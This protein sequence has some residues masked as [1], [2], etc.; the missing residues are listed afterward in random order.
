MDISESLK[1]AFDKL[2]KHKI[3]SAALD[4]EVILSFVLNKPKEYLFAHPKNQLT[5]RQLVKFKKFVRRRCRLEPVAYLTGTKEFYGLDFFINKNVLIPRPE[6][7]LLIEEVIKYINKLPTTNYKLTIAD[8]GTGSG[9]IAITLKK[10][11]PNTEMNAV[12]LSAPALATARRNARFHKVKIKFYRGRL[13]A[14]LSGRPPDIIVANL[15]YL[16]SDYKNSSNFSSLKY[17]PRIALDG[18]RTG[19]EIYEK[20]FCQIKKSSMPK[21]IFCEI[22][23]AYQKKLKKIINNYFPDSSVEI[24]PD[25]AGLPRL[26]IIYPNIKRGRV[27]SG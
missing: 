1:F 14:P 15:P 2:A 16:V 8:I 19:L 20:L 13:L 10:L 4:A 27:S 12:D 23:P 21:A 7:E 26:L 6:T 24:K 17:E 18:G 5:T 25:L 22:G 11:F 9:C 3:T